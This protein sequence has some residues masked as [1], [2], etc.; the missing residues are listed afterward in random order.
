VEG[1][2]VHDLYATYPDLFIKPAFE[3]ALVQEHD[4]LVFQHP[5]YWYSAPALL[6]E[7]LDLVLTHGWAYGEGA[8]TL[9]GKAWMQAITTG[10]REYAYGPDGRNRFTI[11]ELLRPFEA[12]AYLCKADWRP[13]FVVHGSHLCSDEA[14]EE[15]AR[16]YAGRLRALTTPIQAAREEAPA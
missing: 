9:V 7:W 11:E 16:G 5:F 8:G 6:K 2:T 3:R 13:A 12:T 4:A 10:G 15:Q 1:V 14:L